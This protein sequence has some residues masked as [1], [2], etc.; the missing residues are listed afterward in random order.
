MSEAYSAALKVLEKVQG[1]FPF[2]EI[3]SYSNESFF[4]SS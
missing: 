1:I 3:F 2:A 4:A